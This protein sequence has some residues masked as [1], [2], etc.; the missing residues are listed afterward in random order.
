MIKCGSNRRYFQLCTLLICNLNY[1][2]FR[3]RNVRQ[4]SKEYYEK[5]IP[6]YLQDTFKHF[7]SM[8]PETF[9]F[10]CQHLS[11]CPCRTSIKTISS[12]RIPLHKK[13]IMVMKYGA[14]QET[15]FEISDRFNVTIVELLVL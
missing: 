9:E 1:L 2:L 10:L 14:S 5:S 11:T 13:V 6:G 7:F 4:K 12:R 15:L 3:L 8:S